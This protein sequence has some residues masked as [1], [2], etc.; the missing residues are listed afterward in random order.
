MA[1]R[2]N[3][4]T[5]SPFFTAVPWGAIS[6]MAKS[7]QLSGSIAR[8]L[9]FAGSSVAENERSIRKGLV[10]TVISAAGEIAIEAARRGRYFIGMGA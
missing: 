1:S 8:R 2:S 6:S 9:G 7:A 3:F 10:S 4:T 5:T